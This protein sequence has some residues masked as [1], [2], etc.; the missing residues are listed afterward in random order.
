MISFKG[1]LRVW[2][3]SLLPEWLAERACC[4]QS[5][6]VTQLRLHVPL[7]AQR[8]GMQYFTI[9]CSWRADIGVMYND[10]IL[11]DDSSSQYAANWSFYINSGFERKLK[12]IMVCCHTQTTSK[13]C[14]GRIAR[15]VEVMPSSTQVSLLAVE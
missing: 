13:H 6:I 8:D 12:A 4:S 10:W 7:I 14:G 9:G 3:H 15:D 5:S 2:S 11:R 1:G